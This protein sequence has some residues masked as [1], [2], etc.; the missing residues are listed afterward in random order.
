MK[1]IERR[2][3][4]WLVLEV[5]DKRLDA[6]I[7]VNFKDVIGKYIDEG[8]RRIILDLSGV[9]FIDSSGLGALVSSLK[10]MG[11]KGDLALCG[12]QSRPMSMVKL[13]RMDRV[14]SIYETVEDTLADFA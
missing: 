3:K 12:L 1:V 14:F 2:E 11:Q 10:R 5:P 4:D 6:H 9:E 7:A 8:E 13:T